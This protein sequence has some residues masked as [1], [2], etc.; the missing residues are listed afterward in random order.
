MYD[1]TL[2]WLGY[3]PIGHQ[4]SNIEEIL[5]AYFKQMEQLH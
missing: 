1:N 5:G 4:R 3:Y 2:G